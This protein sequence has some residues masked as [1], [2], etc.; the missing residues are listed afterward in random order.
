MNSWIGFRN[1]SL[2]SM[3]SNDFDAVRKIVSMQCWIG[4][5]KYNEYNTDVATIGKIAYTLG[6][7][8]DTAL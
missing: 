5:L 1:K 4:A 7:P 3:N 8:E 6:T 2:A